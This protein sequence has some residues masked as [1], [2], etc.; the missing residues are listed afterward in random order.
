[1]QAKI[2]EQS[3]D[4]QYHLYTVALDKYLRLRIADYDYETH[5]G[6]VWYLFLRGIHSDY[7]GCGIYYT[8]PEKVIIEQITTLLGGGL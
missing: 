7:P 3:Y 5:F 8:R 4:L 1:M 6:G 2:E